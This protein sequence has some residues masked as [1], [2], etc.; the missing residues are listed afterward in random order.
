M[1]AKVVLVRYVTAVTRRQRLI[2]KAVY[3]FNPFFGSWLPLQFEHWSDNWTLRDLYLKN[4][5]PFLHVSCNEF[6]G[7]PMKVPLTACMYAD[8]RV[9]HKMARHVVLR[10]VYGQCNK[11]RHLTVEAHNKAACTLQVPY[12]TVVNWQIWCHLRSNQSDFIL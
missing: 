5:F 2:V 7:T 8:R 1:F 9:W 10:V 4:M 6:A 11:W 3:F 12:K